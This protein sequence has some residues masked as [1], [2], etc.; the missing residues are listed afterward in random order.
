MTSRL[1]KMALPSLLLGFVAAAV[2]FSFALATSESPESGAESKAELV[3]TNPRRALTYTTPFSGGG[4]AG[5]RD[6]GDAALGSVLTRY[7][8]AKGGFPPYRFA[9]DRTRLGPDGKVI[10]AGNLT[11]Q[12]SENLQPTIQPG[13]S[14]AAVFYDGLVKGKIGSTVGTVIPGTPLL[15]DVTVVDAFGT[16][17]NRHNETFSFTLV[18]SSTFKF[19]QSALSGGVQFRRYFDKLDVIAG[20]APYTF[21]ATNVQLNGSAITPDNKAI[22]SLETLGLFFNKTTGLI[23][24]RP[25]YSGTISFTAN[26][27]DGAGSSARS[28]DNT[29]VGQAVS[30]PV[31]ANVRV[32]SDLLTLKMSIKGNVSFG[33]KDT[34]EYSGNLDLDAMK[35]ADLDGLSVTLAVGNYVSPTVTLSDGKGSTLGMAAKISPDGLLQIAIKSDSF[36]VAQSIATTAEL[37]T[38]LD[39]ELIV[40]VTV[41]DMTNPAQPL[42]ESTEPLIFTDKF[43][44]SKFYLEYKFGSNAV[45]GEFMI[46]SVTGRDDK[47][48]TGDSWMINFLAIPP[49]QKPLG[50]LG[51]IVQSTVAIGREFTDTTNVIEQRGTVKSTEKH[52][53]TDVA[54]LKLTYSGKTGKGQV[55]TGLLP[56]RSVLPNQATDI[57]PAF[58]VT[59]VRTEFPFIITFNDGSGNE[60]FGGEGSHKIIP[61]RNEYISKDSAR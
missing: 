24:G 23:T 11:L 46:S 8:Q 31:D 38:G 20:H 35:P 39:K 9:S 14:T 42:I 30:F 2:G 32:N 25:L 27:T 55:Q 34:I 43:R 59:L 53:K 18:D 37:S 29:T 5:T 22:T 41:G 51:N 40:N 15:F 44:N 47:A 4:S 50:A 13:Q 61:K 57:Q 60:L 49:N 7:I 54:V 28:R 21:T 36:G 26:C 16:N 52:A 56:T 19:A 17:P 58:S 10:F 33:G 3:A 45:G 12:E 48:L 6:L 1:F